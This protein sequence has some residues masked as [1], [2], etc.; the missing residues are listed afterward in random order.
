YHICTKDWWDKVSQF[1]ESN[2]G[3][4]VA[5]TSNKLKVN[6]NEENKI[7]KTIFIEYLILICISLDRLRWSATCTKDWWDKVT[8]FRESNFG[9]VVAST[10]NKLEVKVNEELIL[11]CIVAY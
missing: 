4:V 7:I 11:I 2:F 3:Y 6:V 9:Y 1:R 10:S 8:Q 5:S